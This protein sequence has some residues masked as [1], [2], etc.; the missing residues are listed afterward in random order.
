MREQLSRRIWPGAQSWNGEWVVRKGGRT[1]RVRIER[2]AYD[3]QCKA[4]GE[5][6]KD[7][8]VP[9]VSRYVTELPVDAVSYVWKPTQVYPLME[10]SLSLLLDA[11]TEIVLEEEN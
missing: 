2:D 6:W 9:V 3:N 7:G 4:V 10:Q 5:V 8:W 1:F 11:T